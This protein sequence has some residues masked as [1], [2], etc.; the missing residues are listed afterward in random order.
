MGNS[1]PAHSRMVDGLE[2]DSVTADSGAVH[3]LV[4][5]M[6]PEEEPAWLFRHHRSCR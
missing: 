6:L 4:G 5:V 2:G 3:C 1:V